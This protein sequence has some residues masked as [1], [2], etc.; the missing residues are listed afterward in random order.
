MRSMLL[1]FV[2]VLAAGCTVGAVSIDETDA[3]A[4]SDSDVVVDTADTDVVDTGDTDVEADTDTDADTDA[5]TDSDTDTDV[6]DTDTGDVEPRTGILSIVPDELS[7]MAGGGLGDIAHV[8]GSATGIY[9]RCDEDTTDKL[10]RFPFD[11]GLDVFSS[12]SNATV[13]DSGD[14]GIL[15]VV[16]SADG[17]PADAPWQFNCTLDSDQGSQPFTVTVWSPE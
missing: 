1:P 10:D 6:E 13:L 3:P 11:T 8:T 17:P 5:D 7:V 2:L 15:G 4:D 16:S 12:W 14:D 9:V